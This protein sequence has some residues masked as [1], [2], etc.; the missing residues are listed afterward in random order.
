MLNK[1]LSLFLNVQS[2][3]KIISPENNY[4]ASILP[5]ES[6]SHILICSKDPKISLNSSVL[7]I[8][9]SH[10]DLNIPWYSLTWIK[11]SDQ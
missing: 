1:K 6:G 4:K 7:M 9:V 11:G 10:T 8:N 3:A 5:V 2:F